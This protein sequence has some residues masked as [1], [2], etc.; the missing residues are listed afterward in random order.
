VAITP[1]FPDFVH[2]NLCEEPR[3]S[4]SFNVM[5]KWSEEYLPD[6]G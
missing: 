5:L 4:V 1:R 3:V 2:P 6:Q